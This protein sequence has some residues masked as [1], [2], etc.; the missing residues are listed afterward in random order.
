MR[1]TAYRSLVV[2]Q[3]IVNRIDSGSEPVCRPGSGTMVMLAGLLILFSLAAVGCRHK[4]QKPDRNNDEAAYFHADAD[5]AMTAR[6]LVDAINVGERLDS[7]DYDFRGILTDGQG[8][9]I[10]TDSRGN[11]GEWMVDV[12]NDST[13]VIRNLATGDILPEDLEEYVVS[14]LGLGKADVVETT[15]YDDDSETD[16]SVYD[17]GGGTIR[18]E[19]RI[20]PSPNGTDALFV[21]I[22]LS[23]H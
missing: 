18:F 22:A 3:I 9:P 23:A 14:S 19:K 16:L 7:T 13:A 5:I 2:M 1:Q 17:F 6:S 12:L 20:S 21:T 8:R 15:E 10:Y 11:P 4:D